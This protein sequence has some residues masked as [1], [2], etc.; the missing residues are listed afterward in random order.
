MNDITQ[1]DNLS[2][3]LPAGYDL[4]R[5]DEFIQAGVH[6][7]QLGR[8]CLLALGELLAWKLEREGADTDAARSELFRRYAGA[9]GVSLSSLVKAYVSVARFP[10]LPRPEDA[11][12]TTVYEVLSGASDEAD[13]EAGFD[14]V[15]QQGLTA[16]G[17]R[18]VKALRA[19]GLIHGWTLPYLFARDGWVWARDGQRQVR[20]AKL[21]AEADPLARAGLQLLRMRGRV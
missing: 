9:W 19:L 8:T 4:T 12:N 18:E 21:E 2:Q 13:A 1:Y 11:N 5:E 15:T 17:V 3:V 16:A 7:V 20:V 6:L 10:E 14:A